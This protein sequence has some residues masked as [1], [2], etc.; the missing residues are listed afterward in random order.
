MAKTLDQ[1]IEEIYLLFHSD[2]PRNTGA[3]NYQPYLKA[4]NKQ[5]DIK[6]LIKDF[7]KQ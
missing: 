3:N 1:L 4:M 6:N 5:N 7:I 2:V